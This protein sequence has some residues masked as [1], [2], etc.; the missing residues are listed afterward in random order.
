M[1]P[2]PVKYR[3]YAADHLSTKG[4]RKH[5]SISKEHHER[6]RKQAEREGVPIA[7]IV[8]RDIN[9]VLEGPPPPKPRKGKWRTN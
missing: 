8:E 9:S 7:H 6:L 1:A 5:I 3:K 4:R 2:I